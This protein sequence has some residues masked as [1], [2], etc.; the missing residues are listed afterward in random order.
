MK[1]QLL[2]EIEDTFD[3]LLEVFGKFDEDEVNIVPFEGSWTAGQLMRHLEISNTGFN[4]IING[5]VAGLTRRIDE[6]AN[7]IKTDFMNFNVKNK[8]GKNVMPEDKHYDS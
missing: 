6:I 1:E 4:K 2:K 8:S 5:P 3:K 7:D